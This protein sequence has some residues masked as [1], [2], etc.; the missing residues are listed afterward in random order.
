MGRYLVRRLVQTSNASNTQACLPI[1]SDVKRG[2]MLVAKTEDKPSRPRP[3][4]KFSPQGQLKTKYLAWRKGQGR[5]VEAE[6]NRPY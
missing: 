1:T 5:K 4:P 3:R 6:A 2:Q